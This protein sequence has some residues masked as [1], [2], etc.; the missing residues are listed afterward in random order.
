MKE[1]VSTIDKLSFIVHL[2]QIL[3][4]VWQASPKAVLFLTVLVFIQGFFPLAMLYLIKL[5]VD[6]AGIAIASMGEGLDKVLILVGIAAAIG[7]LRIVCQQISGFASETLSLN[8]SDYIYDV[9]HKKSIKVDLEFYE[10]PSYFDTLHRAQ[11]EGPHRPARIVNNLIS[12]GQN[13]VSLTAVTALLIYFHWAVPL[14][15]FAAAIPGVL[16][17]IRF[18]KIMYKWQRKRTKTQREASYL[19]WLIT[20]YIHAKELRLFDLGGL[21]GQQFSNLRKI[22]RT[23]ILGISAK[24]G[25][26]SVFAQGFPLI[27]MFGLLSFI[28]YRAVHGHISIGDLVM[29]YQAIQRG[30]GYFKSLLG[31]ITS[32]YEDNLFI[33]YFYEFM[34]IKEKIKD[35]PAPEK[36]PEKIKQGIF[37]HNVSFTYPLSEK[38]ALKDITFSIKPGEVVALVGKNGAGKSTLTKLLCRLYDPESGTISIDGTDIR[39]FKVK[40]LQS[41]IGAMFQDFAKYHFTAQKNIW[42]GNIRT[43]STSLKIQEAAEKADADNFIRK[44][45]KG[46]DT[47]LGRMF[48][49]GEELSGGQWQKIALARAFMGNG[50]LII[51]DEPASSLDADSEYEVF[52]NFKKLLKGKS[53]V[54]VS[55]RFSTVKMADK[56]IVIQNGKIV[57]QGPHSKL[58]KN[59]GPYA[60]WF[61]KQSLVAG[62]DPAIAIQNNKS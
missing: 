38:K 61:E 14:I 20:G 19:S 21:F 43:S 45:P 55:H 36:M 34:N 51:L 22:L 56:V 46:Y 52:K 60:D 47:I 42:I 53:A 24:R 30:L 49:K 39:K 2:K 54:L 37:F 41:K 3:G 28:V 35:P 7:M 44:L 16:V 33:A 18:S 25:I 1:Q 27:I 9:L 13:L 12:F 40:D 57:E 58:C 48:E 17:R 8:V 62:I 10:N 29:Y 31:G 15:L 6:Q 26:Y 4:F 59:N 23:E 32:L 11:M 50:E 5:I